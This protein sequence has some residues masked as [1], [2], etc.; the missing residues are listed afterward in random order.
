MAPRARPTLAT[1]AGVVAFRAQSR[2]IH[3]PRSGILTPIT[4]VGPTATR[5][6]AGG[7]R[8][9]PTGRVH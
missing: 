8:T 5:S 9:R 7:E 3:S 6:S 4:T 2:R 1:T